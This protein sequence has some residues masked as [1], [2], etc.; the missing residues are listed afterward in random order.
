MQPVSETSDRDKLSEL[1]AELSIVSQSPFIPDLDRVGLVYRAYQKNTVEFLTHIQV[2]HS[3]FIIAL[4]T[5]APGENPH[6]YFD[7]HAELLRLMLNYSAA[8]GT[9]IDHTRR[10]MDGLKV[11][12]PEVYREYSSRKTEVAASGVAVFIKNLRNYMIHYSLP[13]IANQTSFSQNDGGFFDNLLDTKTLLEWDRWG[14]ASKVFMQDKEWISL[15]KTIID[16]NGLIDSLYRWLFDDVPQT[17]Y[18]NATR[19]ID[20]E[21]AI[22]SLER[23]IAGQ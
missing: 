12:D 4:Q 1:K 5:R 7:F 8:I 19:K 13:S 14:E 21:M 9:L 20:L 23:R 22:L 3:D 18:K 10:T 6:I 16:Y 15:S 17:L 11:T 2:P